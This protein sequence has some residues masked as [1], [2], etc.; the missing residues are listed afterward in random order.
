MPYVSIIIAS[1]LVA[2]LAL[3]VKWSRRFAAV[4]I[5]QAGEGKVSTQIILKK[6]DRRALFAMALCYL[7]KIRWLILT[8]AI[9]S[10][11]IFTYLFNNMVDNWPELPYVGMF[12]SV[13]SN[14][15]E[16]KVAVY[17]DENGWHVNN[18]LPD[19]DYY[20]GDLMTNYYFLLKNIQEGLSE[21][22]KKLLGGMLA[23]FKEDIFS[24]SSKD[25]SQSGLQKLLAKAN[26]ILKQ[27]II[28]NNS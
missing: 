19:N 18:T 3:V 17:K 24:I 15:S 7:A 11:K 12:S 26:F 21:D 22:E 5:V 10:E 9:E 27:P 4:G 2:Y 6:D 14:T 25:K 23:R 8:E 16:Y 13:K 1:I 28:A 20:S